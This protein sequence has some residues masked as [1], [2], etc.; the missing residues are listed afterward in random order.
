MAQIIQHR[1]GSIQNLINLDTVY[2]GEMIVAT[3]SI[4]ICPSG[5]A[6]F[7]SSYSIVFVGGTDDYQPVTTTLSGSG[8]PSL[9]TQTYGTYLDGIMWVNTQDNTMYQLKAVNIA[10]DASIACYTGSHIAIA[11]GGGGTTI[12]AAEDGT[13]TDGLFT[14]FIPSTQ[15]GV[16]VDRFNEILKALAPAPAPQLDNLDSSLTSG[17][18]GDVSFGVSN[19]VTD[20]SNVA[21][22]GTLPAV[23][24]NAAFTKAGYRYGIVGPTTASVTGVLNQDVAQNGTYPNYLADSFGDAEKG[25]LLLEVNGQIIHSASLSGSM[26]AINTLNASGSGFSLTATASAYFNDGTPLN[27]FINRQGT[28]TVHKNDQRSGHNYAKVTHKIGIQEIVTNYVDWVNDPYAGTSTIYLDETGSWAFDS[29]E[30]NKISGISYYN[31]DAD[32][33][34]VI[35]YTASYDNL[36][37]KTYPT[38]GGITLTNTLRVGQTTMEMSGS[39]LT[40]SNQ[41]NVSGNGTFNFASLD[42][43]VTDAHTTEATMSFGIKP[44][45][46]SNQFHHPNNW[47]TTYGTATQSIRWQINTKPLLRS[48]INGTQITESDFLYNSLTANSNAYQFE[49]FKSETYRVQYNASSVPTTSNWNSAESLHNT[50]SSGYNSALAVYNTNLVYPSAAGNSGI[51]STRKGPLPQPNYS[52]T[53][54]TRRYVRYFTAR[55]ADAGIKQWAIE[56]SGAG[57]VVQNSSTLFTNS[58]EYFKVFFMRSGVAGDF[59]NVWV[60]VLNNTNRVGAT[61]S[62]PNTQYIPVTAS[63]S[64]TENVV[65]GISVPTGVLAFQDT[66]GGVNTLGETVGVMIEVPQGWTGNLNAIALYY[67]TTSP[68]TTALIGSTYTTL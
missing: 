49:D 9:T 53:T 67:G 61:I 14:D 38:T 46:A 27:V 6:S 29:V 31:I 68:T 52:A 63:P 25:I 20:Y 21:T 59:N 44:A 43:L 37:Q 35:P 55:G 7:T 5:S 11:G 3:G 18:S 10:A 22:V 64:Y 15:I 62:S 12:G 30:I 36:Y 51:F 65:S 58:S 40:T 42:T 45:L 47:A 16:A 39:G 13:Y 4:K 17:V 2:R 23:D 60:D 8:L 28:Y 56:L 57:R 50:G 24:V 19:T 54:G 34:T 48:V 66:T 33:S 41:T 26:G 32:N 1:R